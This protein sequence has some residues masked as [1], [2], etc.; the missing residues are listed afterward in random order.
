MGRYTAFQTTRRWSIRRKELT[1]KV[2]EPNYLKS[3]G[4]EAEDQTDKSDLPARE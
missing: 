3:G 4:H 1:H 2:K